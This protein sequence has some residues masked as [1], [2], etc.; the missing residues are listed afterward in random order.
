V[1][2][3]EAQRDEGMQLN[4]NIKQAKSVEIIL[5]LVDERA[6]VFNSLTAPTALYHLARLGKGTAGGL[7]SRVTRYSKSIWEITISILSS[8][9]SLGHIPYRHP[10]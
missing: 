7:L 1:A 3:R 9:I 2:K 8:P 5:K 6:A 4:K 10:G